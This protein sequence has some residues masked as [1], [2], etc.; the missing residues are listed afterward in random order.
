MDQPQ[1]TGS[2]DQKEENHRHQKKEDLNPRAFGMETI[3]RKRDKIR[4]QKNI[5]QIKKQGKT[6]E[7]QLNEIEIDN[8][9]KK[10]FR[11]IIVK[12][13]PELSKRMKAQIKK[14]QELLNKEIEDLRINRYK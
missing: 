10:E 13:I 11:V 7:E 8:I 6:P 14:I 4:Q 3:C 2:R 9:I 1:P 12:M 5:F